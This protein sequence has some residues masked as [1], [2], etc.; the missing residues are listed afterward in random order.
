MKL[1]QSIWFFCCCWDSQTPYVH[2]FHLN[3]HINANGIPL[4]YKVCPKQK[5]PLLMLSYESLCWTACKDILASNRK[6]IYLLFFF[7]F[8]TVV[9]FAFRQ[10]S[11]ACCQGC[12]V[13]SIHSSSV[14]G[15]RW[16]CTLDGKWDHHRSAWIILTHLFISTGNLGQPEKFL[17][18][19]RTP[20]NWEKTY[21]DMGKIY[22]ETPFSQCTSVI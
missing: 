21:T 17:G 19:W 5:A 1:L 13:W 12:W 22:S 8:F 9:T 3:G 2:M 14:T 6:H 16:E 7:F 10:K 15:M 4:I 20:E 11:A 18:G